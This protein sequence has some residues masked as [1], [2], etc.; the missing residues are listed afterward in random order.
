MSIK[1]IERRH[2]HYF[3]AIAEELHFTRAAE[4]LHMAQPPLSQQIRLMEER[5]RTPLFIRQ[6]R[7]VMLTEAGKALLPMAKKILADFQD[8]LEEVRQMAGKETG[9]LRIG[10]IGSAPYSR[11]VSGLLAAYSKAFPHIRIT[12]HAHTS[13]GQMEA[14][15][16]GDIDLGFHWRRKGEQPR[17]LVSLVI[18]KGCLA[19]AHSQND[20]RRVTRENDLRRFQDDVWL[21]APH[22]QAHSMIHSAAMQNLWRR[23]HMPEPSTR[24][25]ADVPSLLLLVSAGQGVALLPSY[26]EAVVG[27]IKFQPLPPV[28]QKEARYELLLSSMGN[29]KLKE[30]EAFMAMAR[31]RLEN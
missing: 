26:L 8:S 20:P 9:A 1:D 21:H 10:L 25:I 23:A 18:D 22:N 29:K 16:R 2:L 5:L 4:R 30:K 17:A 3:V 31:G 24:E 12:L 7:K 15:R 27:G 14:L 6:Q 11:K 19:L 28:L 13:G